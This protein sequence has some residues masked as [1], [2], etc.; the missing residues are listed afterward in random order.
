MI[1]DDADDDDGDD[2]MLRITRTKEEEKNI[3][4]QQVSKHRK[5]ADHLSQVRVCVFT[6][7]SCVMFAQLTKT[8]NGK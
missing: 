4:S 3:T 6:E 2:K 1:V 7:T 5:L 8:A